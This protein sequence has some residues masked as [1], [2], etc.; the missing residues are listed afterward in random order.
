M[1][2]RWRKKVGEINELCVCVSLRPGRSGRE[3]GEHKRE[4]E[5]EEESY[6]VVTLVV[7]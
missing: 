4:R 7:R 3:A 6:I 1:T 5:E 2:K